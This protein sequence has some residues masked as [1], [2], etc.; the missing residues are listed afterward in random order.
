M[1][2]CRHEQ[3]CPR[4]GELD[5]GRIATTLRVV[6]DADTRGFVGDYMPTK[7][8]RVAALYA[9]VSTVDRGQDHVRRRGGG[10][11]SYVGRVLV[12]DHANG[13]VATAWMLHEMAARGMEP[14]AL[15]LNF[16]NPVLVQSAALAGLPTLDRFETDVMAAV[17]GAEIEI[18]PAGGSG[19]MM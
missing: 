11:R 17:D 12:L 7:F 10:G 18:E 15:L 14:L 9:R 2:T 4:V 5:R 6:V 3:P 8:L 1:A 13:W 16:A 19:R